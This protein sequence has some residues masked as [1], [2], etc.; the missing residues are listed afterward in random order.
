MMPS[1]CAYSFILICCINWLG[2][3]NNWDGERLRDMLDLKWDFNCSII[4]RE[5]KYRLFLAIESAMALKGTKKNNPDFPSRQ[6]CWDNLWS[7]LLPFM[8]MIGFATPCH[9]NWTNR[10]KTIWL[11]YQSMRTHYL[12]LQCDFA[13]IV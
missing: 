3:H 11:S 7:F 8:Q 12:C 6:S 9:L 4:E 13:L 5:L 10:L 1:F 2:R